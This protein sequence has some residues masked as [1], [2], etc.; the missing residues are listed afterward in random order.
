MRIVL[1][2]DHPLFLAGLAR[3]IDSEPGLMLAGTARCAADAVPLITE[4][5]PDVAIL[6]V[7]LPD[8]GGFSVASALIE[9]GSP[10]KIVMLSAHDEVQ[11]Q[12]TAYQI[13]A[14]GYL[15]KGCSSDE[16]SAAISAV[17]SGRLAFSTEVLAERGRGP[18]NPPPT[19]RELEVLQSIRAGL[20]N[21]EIAAELFISERTVHFHVGNLLT[22]LGAGSRTQAVARARELGW[23][24]S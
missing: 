17:C 2:D 24:S 9:S 13:G 18:R 15:S 23:I 7:S 1:V 5:R 14:H 22:K 10:A 4:V 19:R 16:L 11:F 3:F 6:D 8:A 20:S 21:R 12:R